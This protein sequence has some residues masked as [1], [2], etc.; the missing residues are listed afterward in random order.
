[1]NSLD[2]QLASVETEDVSMANDDI[3][4]WTINVGGITGL[5]KLSHW[6]ETISYE[7]RPKVLLTQD[8]NMSEEH[9]KSINYFWDKLGYKFFFVCRQTTKLSPALPP[10]GNSGHLALQLDVRKEYRWCYQWN[11]SGRSWSS[12]L[13]ISFLIFSVLIPRHFD[14]CFHICICLVMFRCC[15]CMFIKK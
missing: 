7:S 10:R 11:L 2:S 12:V 9:A 1:M 8:A 3:R 4:V 6:L 13:I 14:A 5:W 15:V